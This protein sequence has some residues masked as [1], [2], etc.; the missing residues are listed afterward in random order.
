MFRWGIV[1]TGAVSRNFLLGLRAAATPSTVHGVTSRDAANAERFAAELGVPQVFADADALAADEGIDALYVATPPSE[2]EAHALA[3]IRAGRPVLVEKP[4]AADAAAAKRI[5][6][7]ARDRQVFCME[8]MWTRFLPV[9]DE[10]RARLAAG[11]IGEIRTLRGDFLAANEPD[12]GRSLFDP[13]RGGGALRHRGVYPLSLARW[14]L[15][16][17]ESLQATARLGATGVDED[18]TLV[19]QHG[20]GAISTLRA[21]LRTAGACDLT[22]HGTRGTIHLEDP[23][24]R[25]SALRITPV[26]A[27][28]GGG[29]AAGR[30]EALRHSELA[31]GLKQRVQGLARSVGPRTGTRVARHFRGNGFHYEADALMTAVAEGRLESERMPLDESVEIMT[32]VDRARAAW[33]EGA[34]R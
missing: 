2:H 9:L 16:P 15:G 27:H 19:L 1:G 30:F 10:L 11:E 32:L 31:Q 33:E 3:A 20:S 25:P 23:I 28:A 24:Y 6:D 7:A 18:C 12:R 14:L 5:A 26:R 17:V 22:V 13:A 34:Q 4:F 8:G 21:S 29:D